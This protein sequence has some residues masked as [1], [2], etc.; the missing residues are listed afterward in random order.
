LPN[1]DWTLIYIFIICAS[2]WTIENVIGAL[3]QALQIIFEVQRK[4]NNEKITRRKISFP[5]YKLCF[6]KFFLH[7]GPLLLSNL[8]VFFSLF[9]L[10]N[11]KCYRSATWSCTNHLGTLIATKQHIKKFLGVWELTF[12]VLGGLEFQTP[13][14]FG[15]HNFLN[16]NSFSMIVNVLNAKRGR[17]ELLFGH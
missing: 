13:F 2:F 11:L 1:Y 17:I 8:I 12:V 4:R 3:S 16:C 5:T 10:N 6:F 9:I 14:T 7:F 15:G